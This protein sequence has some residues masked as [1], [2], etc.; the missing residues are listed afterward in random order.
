M[1]FSGTNCTLATKYTEYS[2]QNSV[3]SGCSVAENAWIMYRLL[4]GMIVSDDGSHTEVTPMRVRVVP[5]GSVCAGLYRIIS[6]LWTRSHNRSSVNSCA[7][8]ELGV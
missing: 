8:D 3:Q 1:L 7:E 4:S 2:S 5:K 6:R